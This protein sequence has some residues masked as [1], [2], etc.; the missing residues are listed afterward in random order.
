MFRLII[1]RDYFEFMLIFLGLVSLSFIPMD[2]SFSVLKNNVLI[3]SNISF[4]ICFG[5]CAKYAGKSF[6]FIKQSKAEEYICTSPLTKTKLFCAMFVP[7]FI[8]MI[9]ITSLT[10][11][12]HKP[13]LGL[14]SFSLL[15]AL[16]AYSLFY[17]IQF[18]LGILKNDNSIEAVAIVSSI[19]C[20]AVS[21]IFMYRLKILNGKSTGINEILLLALFINTIIVVPGFVLKFSS[22]DGRGMSMGSRQHALITLGGNLTVIMIFTFILIKKMTGI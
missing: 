1:K 18:S 17:C 16:T 11:L 22:W 2:K 3:R 15:E 5:L 14:I 9:T 4:F 7:G 20:I 21:T 12:L 10:H 19:V 13:K 8:A 6:D